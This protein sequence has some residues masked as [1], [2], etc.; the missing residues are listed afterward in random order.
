VQ[1][2]TTLFA[3]GFGLGLRL[4]WYNENEG[5]R[6]ILSDQTSTPRHERHPS[7]ILKLKTPNYA[8]PN[9]P[10]PAVHHHPTQPVHPTVR[11]GHYGLRRHQLQTDRYRPRLSSCLLEGFLFSVGLAF[12][13]VTLEEELTVNP[14][15]A[16]CGVA[17]CPL[18]LSFVE[19]YES[20]LVLPLGL[21]RNAGRFTYGL[22]VRPAYR[23][24]DAIR[25]LHHDDRDIVQTTFGE[26]I[27]VSQLFIDSGNY[28][29]NKNHFSLQLST[30]FQ[31]ALSERISFGLNYR[32]EGLLREEITVTRVITYGGP[33]FETEY[34]RGEAQAHYLVAVVS[35]RW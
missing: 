25:T 2:E 18:Q 20:R 30:D 13:Q 9:N 17:S 3:N 27:R 21:S 19:S 10:I 14:E 11:A 35:W 34:F 7:G 4:A 16:F 15:V 29:V 24:R 33:P 23:V 8:K 1:V 31:Y 22:Q 12:D 26:D 32:Y 5:L 28:R 6:S